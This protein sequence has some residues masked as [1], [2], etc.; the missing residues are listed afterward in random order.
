VEI[1][2]LQQGAT[3]PYVPFQNSVR[4]LYVRYGKNNV[5]KRYAYGKN[6]IV[7]ENSWHIQCDFC[8]LWL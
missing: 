5:R 2:P 8:E 6:A 1:E 4:V 3:V 7:F